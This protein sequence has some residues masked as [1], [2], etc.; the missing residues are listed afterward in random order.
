M[1]P[2]M[3]EIEMLEVAVSDTGTGIPQEDIP[4]LF[5]IDVQYTNIGTSGEKGSGIGLN[6]C[7][8]LVEK[9]GGQIWVE[10]EIGKGTRFK[11][12]LMINH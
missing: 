5:R 7:R 8:D 10:S 9:N 4:K 3:P 12:T 1:P 6:L 2:D 11:F